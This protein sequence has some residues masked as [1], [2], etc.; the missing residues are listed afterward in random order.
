MIDSTTKKRVVAVPKNNR[1]AV[2]IYSW[3]DIARL[4]DCLEDNLEIE[5][6]SFKSI[7]DEN[8]KEIGSELF[9]PT[10]HSLQVIQDA[11]DAI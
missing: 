7:K 8:G 2:K 4:E 11:I 5:I 9:F 10:V 6:E 1:I 3:A